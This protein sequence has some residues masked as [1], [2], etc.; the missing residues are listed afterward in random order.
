MSYEHENTGEA[1]I[2]NQLDMQSSGLSEADIRARKLQYNRQW[3]EKHPDYMRKYNKQWRAKH[4]DYCKRYA[5]RK[6]EIH[7]EKMNALWYNQNNPA[8][9]LNRRPSSEWERTTAI[10]DNYYRVALSETDEP[11]FYKRVRQNVLR[12]ISTLTLTP[13]QKEEWWNMFMQ[14]VTEKYEQMTT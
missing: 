7:R 5:Q 13:E 10:S 3:R 2:V 9:Q 4:P 1:G 6:Q 12:G 14:R 8:K 11:D